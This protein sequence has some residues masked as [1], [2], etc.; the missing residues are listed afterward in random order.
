MI[1]SMILAGGAGERL[2]PLTR[3]RTKPAVLSVMYTG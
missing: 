1:L 3:D 2:S